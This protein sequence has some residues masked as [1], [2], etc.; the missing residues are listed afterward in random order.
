MQNTP[1]VMREDDEDIQ[2]TQLYGRNREEVDRDHLANV[3]SKERHPGLRRLSRL[4]GHQARHGPFGN[5]ESQL[6]QFTVDA[7]RS[8]CWIGGSHGVDNLSDLGAGP[9][10]TELFRLG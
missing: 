10:T 7:W 8:P 9:R 2:H 3:I 1:T 6:F 5:L 4:L